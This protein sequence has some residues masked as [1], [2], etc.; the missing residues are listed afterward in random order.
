MIARR[1]KICFAIIICALLCGPV[2]A[3]EL[4][5][6]LT[7][8]A[9]FPFL[10]PGEPKYAVAGGGGFLDT[11]ILLRDMFNVGPEFG[12]LALPKQNSEKIE[13]GHDTLV[14]LIPVGVQGGMT[15]YPV[16]RLA[17]SAGI[18]GG[19]CVGYTNQKYNYAPWYRA[20]AEAA[21]RINPQWDVALNCS[22][23]DYQYN[24][25]WG[26]PGAAGMTA[27]VSVQFK[28]DT[29]KVTGEV[30]GRVQQDE[31]VFPLFYTVY[32]NNPVG[33]ITLTNNETAEIHNVTVKFR[34]GNYTSSEL[35]CGK[36]NLIRKHR[37]EEI[38]LYA[39]FSDEILK[40]SEA[41]KI[42]GEI[43]VEY[44]LLGQKRTAVSQVIITV[45]NRNQV[46]WTDNS[47]IASYISPNSQEVLELSK[48]LVG[49]ARNQLRS[50][51]NRNMQFAMYLYEG[52]RLSGI[53][54]SADPSTPYLTSHRNPTVLDYIQYPF[55]TLMYK[56][57]DDDDVGILF[58][59]LLESVG[60]KSA[61]IPTEDDFLVA[62][63]LGVSAEKASTLFDGYDRLLVVNGEAWIPVSMSALREG[64]V[65]SRY[66]AVT[67]IQMISEAGGELN[68]VDLEEAWKS[69][70]PAGFSSGETVSVKPVEADV[71]ASVET[72]IARYITAE[73]GPQIAAVQARIKREGPSIELYNNLGLLYVRAGM[74]S[75]A[76]PV[77]ELSA[78]MGSTAAMNNL[79]NIASIQ[80][81][82]DD[83]K[84]WYE[85][86]LKIEPDNKSAQKGLNRVLGELEK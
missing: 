63:D 31:S 60:I 44:E 14:W 1:G 9:F 42:P 67:E 33:I 75:S 73:F 36:V 47:V 53:E 3:V 86:A 46:R 10:T 23:F 49:V 29:E 79:G 26:N 72:D 30:D 68:F 59:G 48:Y 2:S 17:V 37:S 7:P 76:I 71:A 21:F 58:L 65:N 83:A 85:K 13:S 64:F 4:T 81:R 25:Y 50:G 82:F 32:K 57:G 20:Y 28:F 8:S 84:V 34:A 52:I 18:A 69:Y 43:V 40:F 66:K 24:T 12:V 16:S 45:Y 56:T 78:K 11:G 39:D 62:I 77:Y 22:W 35:E 15:F 70:P 51:L 6:K 54:C 5:F 41:G 74:Y 80:K 38:P 55:Q 19:I 61:Y 27:G